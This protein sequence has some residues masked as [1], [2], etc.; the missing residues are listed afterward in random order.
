MFSY[1][2]FY[3]WAFLVLAVINGFLV[4]FGHHNVG[5]SIIEAFFTIVFALAAT[6]DYKHH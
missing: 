3:N 4:G 6:V 1:F 5:V 2:N